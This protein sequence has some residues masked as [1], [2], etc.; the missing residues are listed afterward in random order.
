MYVVTFPYQHCVQVVNHFKKKDFVELFFFLL[1][2]QKRYQV[3]SCIFTGNVSKL[4]NCGIV[5]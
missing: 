3:S 5:T 1:W 4:R 2:Y